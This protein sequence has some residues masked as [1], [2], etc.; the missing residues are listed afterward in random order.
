[1]TD[2]YDMSVIM[3]SNNI[4]KHIICQTC[5]DIA[6]RGVGMISHVL[7][8]VTVLMCVITIVPLKWGLHFN[9]GYPL[10]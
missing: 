10:Y 9:N 3:T 4:L 1:M 5:A 6:A 8:I 7:R 2:L